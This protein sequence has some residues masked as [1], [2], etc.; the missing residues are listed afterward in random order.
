MMTSPD[1]YTPLP[2]FVTSAV[3]LNQQGQPASINPKRVHKVVH[4]I[5]QDKQKI[6]ILFDEK[7]VK[8]YNWQ[9]VKSWGDRQFNYNQG[10]PAS[11]N[12]KRSQDIPQSCLRH[13]NNDVYVQWTN[14]P[15]PNSQIMI[16]ENL[17]KCDI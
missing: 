14:L 11:I 5:L 13:Q 15:N 12:P 2:G 6:L 17:K 7:F 3:A 1:R 4:V 10:Q 8:I 16:V 9:F